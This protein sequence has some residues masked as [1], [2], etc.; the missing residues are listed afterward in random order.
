MNNNT[1]GTSE[2]PVPQTLNYNDCYEATDKFKKDL[3]AALSDMAYV[4][5]EKIFAKIREHDGKFN[6]GILNEFIK[7]LG[8]LPYKYVWNIMKNI[9]TSFNIYF[10]KVDH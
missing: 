1:N 10:V 6:I 7:E 2:M 3:T 5:A 9:Q 4:D 8:Y